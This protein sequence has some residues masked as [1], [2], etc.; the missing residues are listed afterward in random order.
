MLN[1][2]NLDE[3]DHMGQVG[4]CKIKLISDPHVKAHLIGR[5]L[6]VV[7]YISFKVSLML[8]LTYWS[9]IKWFPK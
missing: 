8:S 6:I 1:L 5:G 9:F 4:E 2:L 7:C 3:S